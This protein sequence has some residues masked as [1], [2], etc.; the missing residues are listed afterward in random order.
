MSAFSVSKLI[1]TDFL[2]STT[3]ASATTPKLP[4]FSLLQ[5]PLSFPQSVSDSQRKIVTFVSSKSSEAEEVSTA[6]VEWLYRLP[7][8]TSLFTLTAC[9]ALKHGLGT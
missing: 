2:P 9:L 1:I 7:D 8:K 6:E 5:K 4:C 3:Q